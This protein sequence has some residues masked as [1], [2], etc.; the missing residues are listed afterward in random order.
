MVKDFVDLS[1]VG[2][3]VRNCDQICGDEGSFEVEGEPFQVW[4]DWCLGDMSGQFD[5]IGAASA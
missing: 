4:S 5:V 3:L 2:D 1:V